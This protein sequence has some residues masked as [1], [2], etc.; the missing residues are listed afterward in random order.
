MIARKRYGQP[1]YETMPAGAV[2]SRRFS[3]PRHRHLSLHR[4]REEREKDG[5]KLTSPPARLTSGPRLIR[6]AFL[7]P[8]HTDGTDLKLKLKAQAKEG[9][10]EQ[11]RRDAPATARP[12]SSPDSCALYVARERETGARD[13][14][15]A[16]REE[17]NERE[18]SPFL[19]PTAKLPSACVC[20]LL[21]KGR[22]VASPTS[23]KLKKRDRKEEK[24]GEDDGCQRTFHKLIGGEEG[25]G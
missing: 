20:C 16:A 22:Q 1:R 5:G 21:S 17:R 6:L 7:T 18:A 2:A 9:R 23:T 11:E 12:G 15:Q 8:I 14:K 10:R 4:K 25:K 3:R 13:E 24:T 19:A